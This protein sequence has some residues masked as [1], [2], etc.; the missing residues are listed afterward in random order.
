MALGTLSPGEIFAGRFRVERP[1]AEGGMGAIHVVTNLATGQR[2]ALKVLTAEAL[3]DDVIRERFVAEAKNT[4]VDDSDHVVR[5]YDAGV[6]AGHP[7]MLMELLDGDTLHGWVS[8]RGGLPPQELVGVFEQLCHGVGAA[9]RRGIVHRD[10]KPENV[11]V[12]RRR[13][14]SGA[15]TIKVLDFGVAKAIDPQ[16]GRGTA[17]IAVGTRGWFAPEQMMGLAITPATD[18]WALG[19]IAFFCLTGAAYFDV[20]APMS[21][22]LPPASARAASLGRGAQVPPGF[23]AWFARC[24][25]WDPAQRFADADAAF[26]VLK[27]ALA[28]LPVTTPAAFESTLLAP[29]PSHTSPRPST[30]DTTKPLQITGR[31]RPHEAPRSRGVVAFVLAGAALAVASGATWSALRS[32]PETAQTQPVSA[33]DSRA[34]APTLTPR[35]VACP[36][37]MVLVQGSAAAP[38]CIDRLEVSTA[39]YNACVREGRCSAAASRPNA[40][41]EWA[42]VCNGPRDDRDQH[43]VNCVKW[44]QA[45]TFCR[46]QGRRLPTESE[47]V[48]AAYG[49]RG[50]RF[51]WGD[52][53]PTARH[54]NACG[55]ECPIRAGAAAN[56]LDRDDWVTTAPVGSFPAG[57]SACGALDMAGN[58]AEWVA[59]EGGDG[60]RRVARGGGWLDPPRTPS[61]RDTNMPAYVGRSVGFRCAA[62]P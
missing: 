2:C 42:W 10:L 49:E 30:V 19:L 3:F 62:S 9:H 11:F 23:D 47:W 5:V 20:E 39:R 44:E 7:W 27:A 43:P 6:H 31:S 59:V 22:Q 40:G 54:L 15:A 52:E 36:S 21:T 17:S 45:D 14:A 34:A 56:Y 33:Q 32:S 12:H 61:F 50:K 4:P 18:V 25:A 38:F 57:A 26:A 24:V 51:P 28:P 55:L 53:E 48:L 60:R 41:P 46:A 16:R 37:D 13:D 29:P 1:L 35:P 58:V 8:A